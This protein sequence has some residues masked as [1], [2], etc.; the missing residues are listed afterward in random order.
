[1]VE[2][3][4][5]EWQIT[6]FKFHELKST[7]KSAGAWINNKVQ[8]ALQGAQQS[9]TKLQHGLQSTIM[10]MNGNGGKVAPIKLREG[11]PGQIL[12][13]GTTTPSWSFEKEL[14]A[15]R[16]NSSWMDEN[17]TIQTSVPKDAFCQVNSQFKIGIPPDVVYDIITDPGNKH[18]FENIQEVYSRRVIE[19][20]GERQLVEVDQAAIWRFLCFSGT[21]SVCVLVDQ[22]RRTHTVKFWLAKKGFMKQFE[23]SWKIQP[24]YIDAEG[25]PAP[26]DNANRVASIVFL[27]Q[28][29]QPA[30][31]PP[32]LIKGYVRGITAKATE[33]LTLNLQAEGRRLRQGTGEDG[34]TNNHICQKEAALTD[35]LRD[36][37]KKSSPNR[38][39]KR[40]SRWRLQEDDKSRLPVTSCS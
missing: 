16:H 9:M 36:S 10:F 32:P 19:D 25:G 2:E 1:M 39:T 31:V 17:P 24:F 11:I 3:R 37:A 15:W 4:L 14:E 27:Q 8:D 18:V 33:V 23:G 26:E 12:H 30:L 35:E 7:G 38:R 28:V 22:D 40:K 20:D 5:D 21:F 13:A 6:G 34:N 29:L